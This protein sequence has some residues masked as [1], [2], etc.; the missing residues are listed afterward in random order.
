MPDHS[1]D[2]GDMAEKRTQWA[3]DRTLMAS[4]RTF[5]SWMG[6]GLGAVGVA[7]GLKAVFGS[8]DPTWAAK[9]VASLFL[10]AAILI[11]WAARNQALKTY[12]KLSKNDANIQPSRNFTTLAV[13]LS[14][15]TLAVGMV[16][17]AL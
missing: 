12:E 13:V 5:S 11:Y 17:W 3:E 2:R 14:I 8:F 16:L 15:A 4:E 1:E 6:T 10:L 7:I 9:T